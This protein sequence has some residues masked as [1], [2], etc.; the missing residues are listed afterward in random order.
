M[1]AQVSFEFFFAIAVVLFVTIVLGALA[2]DRL[3]ELKER[4]MYDRVKDVAYAAK[5]E[6]DIAHSMA[7]GYFREFALPV[8]INGYNYTLNLQNNSLA[9]AT[10]KDEVVVPIG[11]VSGTLR[12]GLNNIS[13]NNG[14]VIING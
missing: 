2:A 9:V 13:I 5:N 12:A 7:S 11:A 4:Q 8:D 3:T 1:K 10:Y 14:A 6:I